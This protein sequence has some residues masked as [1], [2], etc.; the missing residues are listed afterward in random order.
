MK[1]Q[2]KLIFILITVFL[3]NLTMFSLAQENSL[4]KIETEQFFTAGKYKIKYFLEGRKVTKAPKLD[5]LTA[6]KGLIVVEFQIDKYGN[7]TSASA[8]KE[9]G[10]TDNIY[11]STKAKQAAETTHFDT[12]Q[13]SPLKQKGK[14]YFEF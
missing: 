12:N 5:I 14:M 4:A 7:V 8:V 13:T 1:K 10:T 6:D 11:L 9:I 2:T 3:T